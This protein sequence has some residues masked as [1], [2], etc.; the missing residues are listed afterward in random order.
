MLSTSLLV[1]V[2]LFQAQALATPYISSGAPYRALSSH[3]RHL[4]ARDVSL[5]EIPVPKLRSD[6]KKSNV[7]ASWAPGHPKGWSEAKKKFTIDHPPLPTNVEAVI[8]DDGKFLLLTNIT[9]TNVIEID[10]GKVVTSLPLKYPLDWVQTSI[11][12][13]PEGA[14]D[15]LAATASQQG[16][17]IVTQQRFSKDG[18]PVGPAVDRE[19]YFSIYNYDATVVDGDGRRLLLAIDD[20]S[21]E[22]YVYDLDKVNGSAVTLTGH[23][24]HL[25][26]VV[27]SPDNKTIATSGFDGHTKLWEAATGKEV[28]DIPPEKPEMADITQNW[29]T[30]FSPDGK[31]L[32]YSVGSPLPEVKLV[33]VNNLTDV[34]TLGPFN[35]WVRTAEWNADASLL[36]LG[37]FGW[38]IVL[39]SSDLTV[40]QEWRI[41]S[42]REEEVTFLHWY[43][44]D[45]KLRWSYLNGTEMYDFE[46]NLKYHWGPSVDDTPPPPGWLTL[47]GN[48]FPIEAKGWF[49]NIDSDFSVRVW[50]IPE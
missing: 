17:Q 27:Y 43:D 6:F 8:T 33:P 38:L 23:T 46:K 13:A 18:V 4:R 19:G 24:D 3:D 1:T 48:W 29:I 47:A 21:N 45:T 28:A 22:V 37:G 12:M 15:F 34:T 20:S 36:A 30:R 35:Y 31:T 7:S 39:R 26:S 40:V 49:G 42:E 14:F 44:N 2:G 11:S 10:T 5:A 9:D 16:Q 41:D 32:L 25:I 50:D